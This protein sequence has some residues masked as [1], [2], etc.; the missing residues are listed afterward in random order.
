MNKTLILAAAASLSFSAWAQNDNNTFGPLPQLK[1]D[2][3]KAEL[4]K[5]LFFDARL[6]G[7]SMMSCASCH[8]PESGFAHPDALGPAYIGSKGFRNV[9]T[10]INSA[11]KKTWFHDGRI[12]TNLNDVTREMITEDWLMN[13]DMRLMQERIKQDPV[14]IEM[15]KK[16]G[17]GEPSNGSVRKAIPEYL[18]TLTSSTT[19]YDSGKMSVPRRKKALSCSKGKRDVHSVTTGHY[20]LTVPLTIPVSPRTSRSSAI[21]CVTRPSLPSICSWAT[22]TT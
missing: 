7:D 6:S 13:M 8:Q 3:A 16:A 9:P 21:Q 1:I 19:A 5:R 2:T 14:Y 20:S 15:F 4:G 11:Y 12:G 10:L 18:K 22:K 17:Y